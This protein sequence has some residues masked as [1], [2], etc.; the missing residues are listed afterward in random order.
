VWSSF[1]VFCE[2]EAERQV[3]FRSS[4]VVSETRDLT[5]TFFLTWLLWPFRRLLTYIWLSVDPLELL[6]MLKVWP[7]LVSEDILHGAG[8]NCIWR[9]SLRRV[10]SSSFLRDSLIGGL[11]PLEITKFILLNHLQMEFRNYLSIY[12]SQ[13][14]QEVFHCCPNKAVIVYEAVSWYSSI[15]PRGPMTRIFTDRHTLD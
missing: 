11:C 10:Q 3:D 5:V 1:V 7:D 9:V 15:S 6:E 12:S 14:K 8:D 4:L 13:S 2:L